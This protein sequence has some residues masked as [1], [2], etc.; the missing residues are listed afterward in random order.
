MSHEYHCM[1]DII[2]P[3]G[4]GLYGYKYTVVISHCDVTV[5]RGVH[6]S[7]FICDGIGLVYHGV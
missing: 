2:C 4:S 6:W 3:N 1:I 5:Y 7:M